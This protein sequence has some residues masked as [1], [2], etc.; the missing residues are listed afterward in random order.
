M[1]L[2]WTRVGSA[3]VIRGGETLPSSKS[4]EHDGLVIFG[5][6]H[7][8]RDGRV[9]VTGHGAGGLGGGGPEWCWSGSGKPAYTACHESVVMVTVGAWDRSAAHAD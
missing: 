4:P 7:E 1:A 9:C 2:P 6:F 8:F 3:A 5:D